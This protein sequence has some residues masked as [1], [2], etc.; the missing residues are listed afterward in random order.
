MGLYG[1]SPNGGDLEWVHTIEFFLKRLQLSIL[2][3]E[4]FHFK[5]RRIFES[6]FFTMHL[7]RLED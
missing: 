1:V 3:L 5:D 4:V 6:L 2:I 7:Q